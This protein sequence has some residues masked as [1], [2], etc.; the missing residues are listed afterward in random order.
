MLMVPIVGYD[1]YYITTDG[2]VYSRYSTKYKNPNGDLHKLS[3]AKTHT[4]YLQVLL[5][6]EDHRKQKKVHRLVAEAFVPN[7]DNKPQINHINGIKTDNR[8]EN[9]EWCTG[10]E[11]V[12]HSYDSLGRVPPLKNKTG[13]EH[14]TSKIVLQIKDGCIIAEFYGTFEA[15]RETGIQHSSI[16]KCCRAERKSAGGFQWKYKEK[17]QK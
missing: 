16:A 13:A 2:D 14:P 7:P 11:N 6:N 12:H 9:L 5:Y 15:G 4:G 1:G 10:S 8:V 3:P 17:E